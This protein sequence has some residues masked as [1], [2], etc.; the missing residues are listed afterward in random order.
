L[1]STEITR[2]IDGANVYISGNTLIDNLI[3]PDFVKRGIDNTFIVIFEDAGGNKET[4]KIDVVSN[5]SITLTSTPTITPV[6]Y[7]IY[8]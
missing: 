2:T 5:H 1:F 6:S 7:T 4:V 3:D 8:A